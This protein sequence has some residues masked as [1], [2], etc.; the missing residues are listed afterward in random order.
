MLTIINNISAQVLVDRC[1]QI[2]RF[3]PIRQID[4]HLPQECQIE[5]RVV[6]VVFANHFEHSSQQNAQFSDVSRNSI[7]VLGGVARLHERPVRSAHGLTEV[8]PFG[9][10]LAAALAEQQYI[11]PMDV[12]VTN[13]LRV[14]VQHSC[15]QIHII[16]EHMC[17][18]KS[19]ARVSEI[20]RRIG[21]GD[22]CPDNRSLA[23]AYGQFVGH[24]VRVIG[25]H[26]HTVFL[27]L[28]GQPPFGR[29]LTDR[30]LHKLTRVGLTHS[31]APHIFGRIAANPREFTVKPDP[32]YLPIRPVAQCLPSVKVPDER[33]LHLYSKLT[34]FIQIPYLCIRLN[35]R[36]LNTLANPWP[37]PDPKTVRSLLMCA[38]PE[39]PPG[40]G[41]A[42]SGLYSVA[43]RVGTAARGVDVVSVSLPVGRLYSDICQVSAIGHHNSARRQQCWRYLTALHTGPQG[44]GSS[45]VPIG[46]EYKY[47][48]ELTPMPFGPKSTA[49][50][51]V[52]ISRA[53]L[54]ICQ[55][56]AISHH[57][58]ARREQCWRY[59]TAL[60]TGPQDIGSSPDPIGFE[61]KSASVMGARDPMPALFTKISNLP[62]VLIVVSRSRSTSSSLVTSA[63][64]GSAFRPFSDTSVHSLQILDTLSALRPVIT[65][66]APLLANSRAVAAPMPKLEPVIIATFPVKS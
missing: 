5:S 23:K 10:Y 34:Q 36:P 19:R 17:R 51:L 32:I 18:I 54:D 55:V 64:T 37:K 1:P 8:R 16:P 33:E 58:S 66:L 49:I 60:H 46:F 40:D 2:A 59:L 63:T 7:V 14:K 50:H 38:S 28:V 13:A 31:H 65:T 20:G 3:G 44:I 47:L 41:L 25:Q 43:T 26:F 56:S 22:R 61:I 35:A 48:T 57:N 39:E 6:F 11:T 52:N 29:R 42:I 4:L 62:N 24:N 53:A 15:I 9:H 21:G 30:K 27:H 12:A 45:P